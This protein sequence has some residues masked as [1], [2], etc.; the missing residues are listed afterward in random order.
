MFRV[1][2][3]GV[4]VY[5]EDRS[6]KYIRQ[7]TFINDKEKLKAGWE[8]LR[9]YARHVRTIY[10]RNRHIPDHSYRTKIHPDTLRLL[11]QYGDFAEP[12]FPNLQTVHL[13]LI[14]EDPIST[15]FYPA[16][17]LSP[18]VKTVIIS[19]SK[20]DESLWE[21]QPRFWDHSDHLWDAVTSRVA[22]VAPTLT[23][24][25]IATSGTL[26]AHFSNGFSVAGRLLKVERELFPAFSTS[27]KILDIDSLILEGKTFGCL[28]HLTRLVKL[29][30]TL[31]H[32]QAAEMAELVASALC[33]PSLENLTL[34]LFA[35]EATHSK[36]FEIL[37]A[38]K[39]RV[40]KLKVFLLEPLRIYDPHP[41]FAALRAERL[42][43]L[44]E[45]HLSRRLEEDS[46]LLWFERLDEPRFE[47]SP[48]TFLPLLQQTP[49]SNLK[50][51]RIDPCKSSALDDR[52]LAQLLR[53][54]PKLENFE[55]RDETMSDSGS[56]SLITAGG[57]RRAVGAAPLLQRLV[58]R[59][60]ATS[61]PPSGSDSDGASS[62]R[63][64][65]NSANET[66]LDDLP[67]HPNLTDLDAC[68]SHL[69]SGRQVAKWLKR[70]FPNLRGVRSFGLYREGLDTLYRF[71]E[72]N[73]ERYVEMMQPYEPCS[74][75]V[76]RWN[77]VSRCFR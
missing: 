71:G 54:W 15:V 16:L 52:I 10:W 23:S 37:D 72:V 65:S 24:F 48:R 49:F 4:V 25:K 56:V 61:V 57:V 63:S 42:A 53:G 5:N 19:P 74:V 26:S 39:L 44:E 1:F 50:T 58:L 55:L 30:L 73:D 34:N 17:V 51:L 13:P 28:N 27:L 20:F 31:V 7:V 6:Y 75:M 68:I 40:L 9:R 60:D 33:L 14:N 47:L 12:L 2:P 21:E 46:P 11:N 8:R 77:D 43:N 32:Q 64:N 45:L 76:D 18:S 62:N 69:R 70:D 22:E 59:F 38:R 29:K 67:P 3:R 41:L 36:F 35:A 66:T